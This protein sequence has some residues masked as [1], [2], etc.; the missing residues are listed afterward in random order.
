MVIGTVT[1]QLLKLLTNF[2]GGKSNETGEIWTLG[3]ARGIFT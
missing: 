2:Q 3:A 1:T